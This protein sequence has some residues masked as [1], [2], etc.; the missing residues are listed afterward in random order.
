MGLA[1]ASFQVPATPFTWFRARSK[2]LFLDAISSPLHPQL[3]LDVHI[4]ENHRQNP[5]PKNAHSLSCTPTAST[6]QNRRFYA[7]SI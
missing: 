4:V 5:P 1:A 2:K 7:S 3:C 6:R